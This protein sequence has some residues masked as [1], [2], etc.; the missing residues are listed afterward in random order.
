MIRTINLRKLIPSLLLP[1]FIG[2]ISQIFTSNAKDVYLNIAKPPLSPPAILF[3][4]IWTFL[5]ILL[6]FS[7]YFV[8]EA[9]CDKTRPRQLYLIVLALNLLW[10]I[11]FFTLK[12]FVFSSV[13]ITAMVIV[14]ALT[15]YYFYNCDKNAGYLF[16]PYVVWLLFA[17]YLNIGVSVLN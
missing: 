16:S 12:W 11:I 6:G 7:S 14:S 5:Y 8:E 4:F 1:L 10:P 3:P 15:L 2:L 9:K 13:I 17:A